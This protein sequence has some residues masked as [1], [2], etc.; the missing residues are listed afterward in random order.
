M[1]ANEFLV[2]HCEISV[3]DLEGRVIVRRS[4]VI[5]AMKEYAKHRGEDKR[6]S[7]GTHNPE[8][9]GSTP[10]TAT[11]ECRECTGERC[12]LL[13]KCPYLKND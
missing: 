5:R 1:T 6:L 13:G 3:F 8:E 10:A 11:N 9:A 12:E 2:K 7:R 4:E